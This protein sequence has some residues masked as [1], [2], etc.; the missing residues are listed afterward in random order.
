MALAQLDL[1]ISVDTSVVHL[2]G[3]LGVPTWLLRPEAGVTMAR[4]NGP[5]LSL[6]AGDSSGG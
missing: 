1:P 4:L 6:V 5:P 2:A 3:A